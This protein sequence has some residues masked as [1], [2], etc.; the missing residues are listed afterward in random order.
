MTALQL[1]F[2]GTCPS[3]GLSLKV[4]RTVDV[5]VVQKTKGEGLKFKTIPNSDYGSAGAFSHA[6]F[7]S[8]TMEC[9]PTSQP[10]KVL[11]GTSAL[12]GRPQLT[13]CALTPLLY[14]K[15]TALSTDHRPCLSKLANVRGR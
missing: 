4:L 5:V 3:G 11:L 13:R 10:L 1:W 12:A 14:N 7:E 2:R 8:S 9:A 6:P 15:P